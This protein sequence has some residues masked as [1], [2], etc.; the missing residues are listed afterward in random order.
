MKKGD[1]IIALTV[2][3]VSVIIMIVFKFSGENNRT[4]KI[5]QNNKVIKTAS[6]DSNTAFDLET[7]LIKIEKGKVW[8]ESASCKNQICVNHKPISK[9]G[10]VIACLPNKVIIE[11]E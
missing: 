11:I 3:L 5:S 2:F 10:E 6:L 9:R 7:N 8:V 4:V 1:F